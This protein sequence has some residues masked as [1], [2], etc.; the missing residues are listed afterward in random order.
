MDSNFDSRLQSDACYGLEKLK[1]QN[2][3]SF[4]DLT[5]A[6]YRSNECVVSGDTM[7]EYPTSS[8]INL[9]NSFAVQ[10]PAPLLGDAGKDSE[11]GSLER[12][13]PPGTRA[14]RRRLH[15][16]LAA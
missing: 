3:P 13:T 1:R 9:E 11:E 6:A 12:A 7:T 10:T 2:P 4:L 16:T 14:R 15:E 8:S 5:V